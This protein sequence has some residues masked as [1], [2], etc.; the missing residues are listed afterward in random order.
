MPVCLPTTPDGCSAHGPPGAERSE[1]LY[2]IF[3]IFIQISIQPLDAHYHQSF[4]IEQALFFT[5]I[6]SHAVLAKVFGGK[7]CRALVMERS[8]KRSLTWPAVF[9]GSR[10]RSWS[11]TRLRRIRAI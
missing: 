4:I 11:A 2:H 5:V 10:L 6:R 3:I 1:D 8:R 7:A 9:D